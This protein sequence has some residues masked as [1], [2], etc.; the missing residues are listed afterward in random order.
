[1]YQAVKT[2]DKRL[3]EPFRGGRVIDPATPS[4]L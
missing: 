3:E 1:M 2:G 4:L